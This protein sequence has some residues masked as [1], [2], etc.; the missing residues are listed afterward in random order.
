M[1][2]AGRSADAG[3]RPTDDPVIMRY[4]S[5]TCIVAAIMA[6]DANAQ[7]RPDVA[8]THAAVVADHPLAAATGAD[9]LKRGGNAMD[10]AIAMAAVRSEEHTSELQS[11]LHLVCRPLLAKEKKETA[12]P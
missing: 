3:S 1:H 6:N 10:A 11:R 9:V 4:L 12:T 5:L 2:R 7:L 8:G